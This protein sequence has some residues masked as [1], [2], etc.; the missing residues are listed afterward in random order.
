MLT[1]SRIIGAVRYSTLSFL[2]S[3]QT[4][5]AISKAVS[6]EAPVSSI[7]VLAIFASSKGSILS[8]E[9]LTFKVILAR[10]L[11]AAS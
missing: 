10:Y 11:L 9:V 5:V 7:K 2:S 3:F 4:S 8:L 1:I 6:C